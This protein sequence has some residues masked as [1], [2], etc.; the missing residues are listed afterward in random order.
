ME[1]NCESLDPTL[2]TRLASG[3]YLV[4]ECLQHTMYI[5]HHGPD[6]RDA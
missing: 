5:T 3:P 2:C 4:L 1:A 6:D